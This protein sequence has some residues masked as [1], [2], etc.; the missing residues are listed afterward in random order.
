MSAKRQIERSSF[1]FVFPEGKPSDFVNWMFLTLGTAEWPD[2]EAM[3]EMDPIIREQAKSIRAPLIPKDVG[4][5]PLAPNPAFGKQ[6]VVK[7]DNN[8][9][10]LI[11]EGYLD[12]KGTPV[13]TRELKFPQWKNSKT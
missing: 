13:I 11:V 10:L 3:A 1:L 2:S 4:I 9:H 8:R 6:V 12:F 7:F 5:V